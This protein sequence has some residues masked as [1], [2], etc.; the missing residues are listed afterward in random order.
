MAAVPFLW[1]G[2]M[3]VSLVFMLVYIWGREFP[4]AQ[5]SIYGLVSLKVSIPWLITNL[6]LM[7]SLFDIAVRYGWRSFSD[8][9][10]F[11]SRLILIV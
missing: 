6:V 5:V 4:N 11:K 10:D 8:H 1:S 2:F 7:S 3:G 9:N